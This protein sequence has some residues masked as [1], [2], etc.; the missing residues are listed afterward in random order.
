MM[1][2]LL[3]ILGVAAVLTGCASSGSVPRPFPGARTPQV[4]PERPEGLSPTVADAVIM[5]ALDLRGVRYRNGG[6]DPTGFDCSGFVQ[7]VFARHGVSLPRDTSMQY[8]VGTHIDRSALRPGDLVFFETVSRGP[9]HVGLVIGADEF[10]H[11]PS[12]RGVVR[13]EHLSTRYWATRYLGARRV[14]ASDTRTTR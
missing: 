5:T 7:W 12:E 6:S 2:R 1:S 3:V 8:D 13:V 9:S 10:V 11:A 4:E 14:A